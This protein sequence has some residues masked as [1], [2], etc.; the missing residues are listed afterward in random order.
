MPVALG[1]TMPLLA[2]A[3][4][5]SACRCIISI[6]IQVLQQRLSKSSALVLPLLSQSCTQ[7]VLSVGLGCAHCVQ[8]LH[9]TGNG[10]CETLMMVCSCCMS[11]LPSMHF[12]TGVAAER[13]TS[14]LCALKRLA[15]T[16]A[17]KSNGCILLK[18][19]CLWNVI[20]N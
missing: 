9:C 11:L 2:C 1:P 14:M 7:Y 3:L 17:R 20:V 5:Y 6:G 18:L 4:F 8:Q 15:Y 13:C 10:G 19:T 16:A 12:N